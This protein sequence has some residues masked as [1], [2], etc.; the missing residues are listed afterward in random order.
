MLSFFPV[1]EAYG[2]I[3]HRPS[4]ENSSF[5]CLHILIS[6]AKIGDTP[7]FHWH[8]RISLLLDTH[9]YDTVPLQLC[10]SSY[11]FYN[12]PFRLCI[13]YPHISWWYALLSQHILTFYNELS[14][15]LLHVFKVYD[16]VPHF[17]WTPSYFMHI[18]CTGWTFIQ[19]ITPGVEK[20]KWGFVA[21]L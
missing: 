1:A 21:L 2:L 19:K 12:V 8:W 4:G 15:L 10:T 18:V 9:P 13:W 17:Y 16:D 7:R 5:V 11:F 14:S 20:Q 3:Y 6:N